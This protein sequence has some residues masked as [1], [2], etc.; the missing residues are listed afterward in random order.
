MYVC[1]HVCAH[2]PPRMCNV[3]RKK[4]CRGLLP[5]DNSNSFLVSH[6]VRCVAESCNVPQNTHRGLSLDGLVRVESF[7]T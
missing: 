5:P 7:S 4:A 1:A 6:T 3:Q 2:V